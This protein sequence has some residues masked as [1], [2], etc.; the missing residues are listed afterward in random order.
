MQLAQAGFD[1]VEGFQAAAVQWLQAACAHQ[2][3]GNGI[4]GEYQVVATAPGHQLGLEHFAA[5][6]DVV[7]HLDTGF[8]RELLEGVLG[9]I[10]G[11]VVQA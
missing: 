3:F 5:V 4:T 7:D 8:G 1:V 9:K 2:P 10:V 6:H 11:P